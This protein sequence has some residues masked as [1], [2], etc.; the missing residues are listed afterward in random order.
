MDLPVMTDPIKLDKH[1]ASYRRVGCNI[2]VYSP[3]HVYIRI[4]SIISELGLTVDIDKLPSFNHMCHTECNAILPIKEWR[5]N[6]I[7]IEG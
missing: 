7:Q 1:N 2:E 3:S 4:F 5:T 6:E